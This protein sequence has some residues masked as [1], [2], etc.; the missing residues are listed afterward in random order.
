MNEVRAPIISL[1]RTLRPG[2]FKILMEI[3][4]GYLTEVHSSIFKSLKALVM[5]Y[6]N[7]FKNAIMFI[8]RAYTNILNKSFSH[9]FTIHFASQIH[10]LVNSEL[11]SNIIAV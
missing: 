11:K 2:V 4:K 1:N 9:Y 6:T 10:N 8:T 3:S 7:I 5:S